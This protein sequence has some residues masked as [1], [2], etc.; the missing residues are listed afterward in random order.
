[1]VIYKQIQCHQPTKWR[2]D[3]TQHNSSL[4]IS[5]G[6]EVVIPSCFF[7]SK[8]S[9]FP[10]HRFVSTNFSSIIKIHTFSRSSLFSFWRSWF[11]V[12]HACSPFS[13]FFRSFFSYS[14]KINL[15]VWLEFFWVFDFVAVKE[16]GFRSKASHFRWCV[17]AQQDQRL[18]AYSFW[19]GIFFRKKFFFFFHEWLII[20]WNYR[21]WWNT[22][23]IVIMLI[24]CF[25]WF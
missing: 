4:R 25:F 20:L 2:R 13:W 21:L 12:M 22:I 23:K 8:S 18:L 19:K 15:W 6:P 11:D 1:M 3:L 5:Q 16:N 10:L 7:P 14:D 17:K 9:P 24:K